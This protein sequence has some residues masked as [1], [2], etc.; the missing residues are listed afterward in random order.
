VTSEIAA[1]A[2]IWVVK[3]AGT[4]SEQN[5]AQERLPS[6]T[7]HTHSLPH[8]RGSKQPFGS[9]IRVIE[10]LE[11]VPAPAKVTSEIAARAVI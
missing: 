6:P 5:G 9:G 4:S 1:R 8:H 2:V 7:E 3:M 10:I 11:R